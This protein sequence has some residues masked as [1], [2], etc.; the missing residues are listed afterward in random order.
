MSKKSEVV[1]GFGFAMQI[2]AMIEAARQKLEVS[3]E[4]FHVLGTPEGQEHVDRMVLG[5]KIKPSIIDCNT[6]PFIPKGW[7]IE[8]HQKGGLLT[9]DSA[10]QRTALYRSGHQQNRFTISG[11]ELRNELKVQPVL[12]ANALDFLLAH[13]HL[14]PESWKG[15][16]V[17]FWGTIYRYKDGSL[18][19]RCLYYDIDRWGRSCSWLD[20]G[21]GFASPAALRAS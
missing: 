12:N 3:D 9:W 11:N 4:D 20:D 5:L 13:A 7:N 1:R 10:K 17:F 21:W 18:C 6:T 8:E 19:V 2:G 14:I 16:Y 15:Q